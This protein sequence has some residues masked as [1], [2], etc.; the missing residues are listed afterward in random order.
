MFGH[1]DLSVV[2]SDKQLAEAH[3]NQFAEGANIFNQSKKSLNWERGKLAI[4]VI[5]GLGALATLLLTPYIQNH[6]FADFG[7]NLLKGLEEAK[8]AILAGGVAALAAGALFGLYMWRKN[9]EKGNQA[10]RELLPPEKNLSNLKND[11]QQVIAEKNKKLL[12]KSKEMSVNK[13]ALS[14]AAITVA[15]AALIAY[16]TYHH[17]VWSLNDVAQINLNHLVIGGAV[18][19]ALTSIAY[20]I[21]K[22]RELNDIKKSKESLDNVNTIL[23]NSEEVFSPYEQAQLLKGER[24]K[25]EQR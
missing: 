12:E 4:S 11:D 23:S 3:Y 10:E 22:N 6:E 13:W 17:Q 21:F 5:L 2:K 25:V 14:I 9:K 18:A 20:A 19:V 24:D 1:I 15:V 16:G 7:N 8:W